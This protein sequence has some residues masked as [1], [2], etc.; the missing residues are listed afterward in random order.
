MGE[1]LWSSLPRLPKNLRRLALKGHGENRNLSSAVAHLT[2]LEQLSLGHGASTTASLVDLPGPV[3]GFSTGVQ[4][5]SS[6]LKTP[7]NHVVMLAKQ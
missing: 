2:S 1:L 4:F 6:E 7:R 3:T 5:R